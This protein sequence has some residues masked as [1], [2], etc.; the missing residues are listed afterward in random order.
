M[1]QLERGWLGLGLPGEGQGREGLLVT[2]AGYKGRELEY[3]QV[4][5]LGG[6]IGGMGEWQKKRVSGEEEK[7]G[8]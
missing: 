6:V 4:G 2:P 7:R 1:A 3:I 5:Y 8:S